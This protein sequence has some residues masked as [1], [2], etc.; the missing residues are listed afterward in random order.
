M[1]KSAASHRSIRIRTV[2]FQASPPAVLAYAVTS[3]PP[4]GPQW[5]HHMILQSSWRQAK[6]VC[7]LARVVY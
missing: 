7:K 5:R 6:A 1:R 4:S 3:L 2:G